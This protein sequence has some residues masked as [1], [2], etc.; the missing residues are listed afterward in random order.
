MNVTNCRGCGKLFPSNG[1]DTCPDC[2]QADEQAFRV[3]REYLVERPGASLDQVARATG[4]RADV[5][6][7]YLRQG[8]LQSST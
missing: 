1:E 8:R 6:L 3:V 5:I 7:R 2:I 4:V